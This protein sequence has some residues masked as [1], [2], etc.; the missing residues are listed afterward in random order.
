MNPLVVNE[1]GEVVDSLI[2][3]TSEY[4]QCA[5]Q[6]NTKRLAIEAE[7]TIKIAELNAFVISRSDTLTHFFNERKERFAKLDV[8]ISKAMEKE[9]IKMLELF[10]QSHDSIYH[11]ISQAAG[12]PSP[13][14]NNFSQISSI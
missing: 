12:M 8:N 6:E 14:N 7:L 3:A 2:K 9:N 5:K 4:A 11:A 10:L 13:Q 1:V